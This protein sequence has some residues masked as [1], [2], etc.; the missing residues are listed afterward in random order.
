MSEP[1]ETSETPQGYPFMPVPFLAIVSCVPTECT[2]CGDKQTGTIHVTSLH[3][4]EHETV[5]CPSCIERFVM[6]ANLLSI[7][8]LLTADGETVYETTGE[9]AGVS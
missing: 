4:G 6:L 2:M 9:K 3:N 7:R 8:L 1:K 5:V